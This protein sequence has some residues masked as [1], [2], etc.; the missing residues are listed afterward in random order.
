[1]REQNYP[2][3]KGLH[4]EL[5]KVDLSNIDD[6]LA[7]SVAEDQK[8]FVA[9]NQASIVEAYATTASGLTAL[10]F[11]IYEQDELVG[12]VMF[13]YDRLDEE[14]P[15]AADGNYCLWRFMIDQKFQGRGYG[16]KAL[17]ACVAYLK[18]APC[19]PA[20]YCWLSYEPENVRAAGLY[21]KF[22]FEETGE[23]CGGEIV[24]VLKL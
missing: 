4:M 11:G 17:E 14:D 18:T 23:I 6:V 3:K 20:E 7:L 9:S 5:K 12:F 8:S 1:M 2:K 24:T 10:P 19:G 13:G 15:A 22:G 21:K 16:R